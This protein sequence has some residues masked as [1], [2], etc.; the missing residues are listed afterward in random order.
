MKKKQLKT[1]EL[2]RHRKRWTSKEE[3]LLKQLYPGLFNHELEEYFGRKASNIG[4]K[5]NRLGLKKNW[6]N[7]DTS[8]IYKRRR[9]SKIE[10]KRLKRLY[11]VTPLPQ[12]LEH[13]PNRSKIAIAGQA[14][15]LGLKKSYFTRNRLYVRLPAKVRLWSA[16]QIERLRTLWLQGYTD[17]Q[18]AEI[19]GRAIECVRGQLN[20]QKRN[21]G[22]Q[23]KR[24]PWSKEEEEYLIR[25]YSSM[26][27]R[28]IAAMLGRTIE[29][30]HNKAVRLKVNR[31]PIAEL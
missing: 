2:H 25:H 19:M 21:S 26:G 4:I 11:P 18:I 17:S 10:I 22:L 7:P 29:M 28:Q 16:D 15:F 14:H 5:A 1:W 8:W 27:S 13:F 12:L 6:I 9:W 3:D 30:V 23:K 31:P 20:R 24:K